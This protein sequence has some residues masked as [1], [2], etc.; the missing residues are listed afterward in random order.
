MQL[1]HER[2]SRFLHMI[3]GKPGSAK[4]VSHSEKAEENCSLYICE[5]PKPPKRHHLTTKSITGCTGTSKVCRALPEMTVTWG[6]SSQASLSQDPVSYNEWEGAGSELTH[7][8]D[9][10]FRNQN[11]QFSSVP[12]GKT[13]TT[14]AFPASAS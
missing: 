9:L 11:C 4:G 8:W 2:L 5:I 1:T 6:A 10:H 12:Q 3:Y 7:L 14:H 13:R